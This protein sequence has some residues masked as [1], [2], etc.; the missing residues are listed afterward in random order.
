MAFYKLNKFHWHLTDS[1]GWRLEIKQYPLLTHIGGIGDF[2]NP[3]SKPQFYTQEDIREIVRY[4]A[5]RKITVIPEIDMPGHATAA[6]RA[7]PEFSGGGSER[8]P[9]FTFNPGYEG[10]Y[11]YLTNILKETDVLFPSQMIHLGGD[12]V[13]FGNE[14]WNNNEGIKNLMKGEGLEN[15]P[16]VEKYFMVRMADSLYAMGNKFLAWDE[17]ADIALP[18]DRTIIFWW[19]HDKTNELQKALDRNYPVVICPRI[20]FYFDFVQHNNHT[21]GRKWAGAFSD[22]EKVYSFSTKDIVPYKQENQVLG[23]QANLWTEE[24][25]TKERLDYMLFPRISAL[26]ES[27][28]GNNTEYENYKNRLA[29]HLKLYEISNIYFYDPISENRRKEPLK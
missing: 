2:S 6:N 19:R 11:Q 4:A 10:T 12:E 29:G 17:M 28:W 21:T 26:A 25:A 9:E 8:Y 1:H 24:I 18:T 23:I 14:A 15:L 27:S 22:L 7:Y 5:E 13:H 20:P 3:E 16:E